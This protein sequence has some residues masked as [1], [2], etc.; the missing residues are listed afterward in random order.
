M[1][2]AASKH[3]WPYCRPVIVVDGSALKAKFG[4]MLLT[5]CGHDANGCIFPLAFGIVQSESNE[6][7]TW[8]FKKL[9]DSI[10]TRESLAIVADRHKGIEYAANLVS[11]DAAFGIEHHRH[12]ESI[13]NR[14]PDMHRYLVQTDPTKWS[15]AYFN[16]WRYAIMTTN[17]AESLNNVDRKARLMLVGF[18]VEWLRELQ[19]RWFF[20]RREEAL[21]LTSK[22]A[23]KVEKLLCTNFSIGLIVTPRP[24]DQF[25]YAVTNNASQI[26]IVDM[27][28]M[29]CT[30]RR[31]Q[32]DQ[33]PCPH[34]MAVFHPIDSAD[35]WDVPEEVRS[36]I[37]NSFKTKCGLGRPWVRRILSQGEE[38]ESV[39]FGR[40]N[41]YGHNRQ[42]CTNSVPLGIHP[43]RSKPSF[44]TPSS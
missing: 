10:G 41:G 34:A 21:K 36:Q 33:I 27:S 17:I 13:R 15:R 19:Q 2:L 35:G 1:C 20:Q 28:E 44:N 18:L 16:G 31:F 32:I 40:C 22:L 8:F 3:S 29:T 26:W 37:V 42:T 24:T 43:T 30:C 7:W 12:M 4:G 11:P 9:R 14:N 38:H 39:R 23:P 25:K 5:A 6:S